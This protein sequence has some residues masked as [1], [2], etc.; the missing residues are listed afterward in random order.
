MRFLQGHTKRSSIFLGSGPPWAWGA[1]RL[2]WCCLRSCYLQRQQRAFLM[3]RA[4][5]RGTRSDPF[6]AAPTKPRAALVRRC[7]V[8]R[9]LPLS[10]RGAR[11]GGSGAPCDEEPGL[12]A[13]GLDSRALRARRRCGI[14]RMCASDRVRPLA[15]LRPGISNTPA[16]LRVIRKDASLLFGDGTLGSYNGPIAHGK[17]YKGNGG[18]SLQARALLADADATHSCGAPL[19]SPA[20]RWSLAASDAAFRGRWA[21]RSKSVH[22]LILFAGGSRWWALEIREQQSTS[23][24]WAIPSWASSSTA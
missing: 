6:W 23:Q 21:G 8:L 22:F 4:A 13:G 24:S 15:V 9:G 10:G 19:C 20:P 11:P 3:R 17:A 2:R 5:A 12:T 14:P 1:R 18:Y 16:V 7:A